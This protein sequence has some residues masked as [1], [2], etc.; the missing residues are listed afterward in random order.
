VKQIIRLLSIC[1]L[2][3]GLANAQTATVKRNVNLRLDP[4]TDNTPITTLKPK[5]KLELIEPDDTEGYFHVET[6]DG[7]EGW[8]WGKNIRIESGSAPLTKTHIGSPEL[9]PNPDLTPGLADTLKLSDL[10]KRYTKGC[11][12]GKKSCT[13]SQAHRNVPKSVHTQVYEEYNVPDA[14]R[15]IQHGEV[16]HFYPLCAGGSN[17]IKNLW[18]QRKENDWNGRNFGFHEKDKLETYVCAQIKAHKM[19][20]KDAFN[21]I[22][23]DWV[24]FYLDEGLDAE[25]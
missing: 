3:L 2:F 16:D 7:E 24:K 19:N 14:D 13:Y 1:L 6:T 5:A 12:S 8:V 15:N 18:Y 17:D 22:K 11:P 9:Y 25:D 10:T 23:S 4:S 20:P 21:R